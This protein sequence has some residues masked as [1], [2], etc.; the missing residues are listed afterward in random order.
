MS[1]DQTTARDAWVLAYILRFPGEE[2]EW[3][4]VMRRT[5]ASEKEARDCAAS[6]AGK[7]Q[8]CR[9]EVIL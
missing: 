2:G 1:Q 8:V 7:Y 6:L 9:V 4:Q 5:F 3:A